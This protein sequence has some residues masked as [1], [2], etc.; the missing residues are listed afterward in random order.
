MGWA[1]NSR[2][3]RLWWDNFKLQAIQGYTVNTRKE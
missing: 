1:S 2:L 3:G